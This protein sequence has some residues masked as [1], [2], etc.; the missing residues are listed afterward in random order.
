VLLF[1]QSDLELSSE[2]LNVLLNL[3]AHWYE[4]ERMPFPRATKIARRMGVSERTVQRLLSRLCKRDFIAKIRGQNATGA[5]AYDLRPM[6]EK[7][8]PFAKKRLA[9]YPRAQDG[10]AA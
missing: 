4:P 10:E 8:R 6:I 5:R 2:E 9:L 7:L 1:H 3:M